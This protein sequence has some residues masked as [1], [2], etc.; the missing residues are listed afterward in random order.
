MEFTYLFSYGTLQDRKI[1]LE[2]FGRELEGIQDY[3]TGYKLE[4]I[5]LPKNH[6]Q[7]STYFIAIYT[8]MEAD[9]LEGISYRITSSE[10]TGVDSYEGPAYERIQEQLQSG[11]QV[12]VYRKPVSQN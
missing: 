8:G 10:L 7:A 1:Q 5:Q 11:K 6:P 12:W 4:T 2:L 9:L 3:L